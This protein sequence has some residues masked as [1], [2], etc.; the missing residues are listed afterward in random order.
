MVIPANGDFHTGNQDDIAPACSFGRFC[1]TTGVV[2]IS[3]GE[4]PDASGYRA[5]DEF[6]WCEHS[7]GID[8]VGVQINAQ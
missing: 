4:Q 6:S 8:G 7:I 3:Q 1:Q 2:V 5:E